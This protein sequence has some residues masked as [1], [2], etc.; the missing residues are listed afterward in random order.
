M[1]KKRTC[2]PICLDEKEYLEGLYE[3]NKRFLFFLAGQYTDSF[4]EREDLVQETLLRLIFNVAS[5]RE[6]SEKKL[7]KYISLT[8]KAAFLDQ[9]KRKH[10]VFP[11]SLDDQLLERLLE[12]DAQGDIGT[13]SLS[14]HLE[15]ELLKKGL[16]ARDW[17]I[18]E[19]KYI[20]GYSQEELGQLLGIAPDS[21]RMTLCRA[22]EKARKLLRSCVI[23][24]ISQLSQ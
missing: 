22:R 20:L 10:G 16:S 18:L 24:R 23:P 12:E 13:S 6:L 9:E 17:L 21:V 14:V 2:V 7:R 5:I 8:V 4:S 3:E 15:V 11:V 19:G 1:P